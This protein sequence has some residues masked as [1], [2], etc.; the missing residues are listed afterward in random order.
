MENNLPK[1]FSQVEDDDKDIIGTHID[2]IEHSDA[3]C[4]EIIK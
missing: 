1:S 4:E 2:D 3:E